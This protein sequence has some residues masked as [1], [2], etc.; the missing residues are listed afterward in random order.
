MKKKRGVCVI[1]GVNPATS[2][3]HIPPKCLFAI[4]NRF[5]LLKLP[6][7]FECNNSTSTD[8]EYLRSVLI[9]RADVEE[10]QGMDELR[11]LL[12]RS[13]SNPDQLG[14][15]KLY[16]GAVSF[17]NIFTPTGIYLGNKPV[18]YV[19]YERLE[20]ILAKIIRG[21]YYH[22]T[23]RTLK[24]EYSIKIFGQDDLKLQ[25][26]EMKEFLKTKILYYLGQVHLYEMGKNTFH[27]KYLLTREDEYAGAWVLRFYEKV[28][29]LGLVL[30]KQDLRID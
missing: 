14:F 18:L 4:K 19:N 26:L 24:K 15:Q 22:H 16:S 11:N 28:H 3:D 30:K 6:A 17:K 1:C 2:D 21:L 27:Y 23:K 9:S 8:D 5:N 25:S 29:F 13:L 7:C 20:K 10:S 12:I